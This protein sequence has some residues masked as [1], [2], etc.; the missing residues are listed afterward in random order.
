MR[1]FSVKQFRKLT[2]IEEMVSYAQKTLPCLGSG[3]SRIVFAYSR[4]K[5]LKISLNDKGFEQ[6]AAEKLVFENEDTKFAVSHIYDYKEIDGKIVWLISQIVRITKGIEEFEVLSGFSWDA[7]N[8]V[9]KEFAKYN[10][11]KELPEIT[12]DIS[13]QYSKRVSHM[14]KTGD[15]RN[16]S[17]YEKLL[18]DLQIMVSSNF[19]KGIIAAMNQNRLMPGDILEI[20]HYGKTSCGRVVLLDYGL[21]EAVA[22]KFYRKTAT[23]TTLTS[24]PPSS[25][26]VQV[27]ACNIK[28]TPKR[29]RVL[30]G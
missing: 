24:K 21:T 23:T 18:V 15:E 13:N 14:R 11:N 8:E 5:A 25:I 27:S 6:N 26:T 7:Y 16:A 22:N 9:I 29:K 30:T 2:S 19:F 10:A 28:T 17:Y 3:S 12:S 4:G 20:E 1:K